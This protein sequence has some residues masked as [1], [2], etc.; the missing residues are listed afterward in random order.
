MIIASGFIEVNALND[1]KKVIDELKLRGVEVSNINEEK[2]VFLIERESNAEIKKELD[3]LKE[4][5]GVRGVYLAYY[6]LEGADEGL[7]R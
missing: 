6:S 7:P 2:I 5:E 1:V 4:T 3:S